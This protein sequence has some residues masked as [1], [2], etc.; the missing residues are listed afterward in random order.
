MTSYQRLKK[1]NERLKDEINTVKSDLLEVV[2]NPKS[3]KSHL[4]KA[5]AI[6]DDRI[7]YILWAGQA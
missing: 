7:E 6:M 3:Y 5:K 1:E 4:I 2:K